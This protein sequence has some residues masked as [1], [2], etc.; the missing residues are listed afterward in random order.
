MNEVLFIASGGHRPVGREIH[1]NSYW[2]FV[3]VFYIF[4]V[5]CVFCEVLCRLFCFSVCFTSFL[6]TFLVLRCSPTY[7]VYN[8]LLYFPWFV[9]LVAAFRLLCIVLTWWRG[10]SFYALLSAKGETTLWINKKC[11]T[12]IHGLERHQY[13]EG[14]RKP[15]KKAGPDDLSHMNDALGYLI[16][17]N[18]PVQNE[19][20]TRGNLPRYGAT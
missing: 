18:M 7:S 13:D 20:I 10:Y 12:L 1:Q 6:P 5:L 19:N 14:T 17:Y 3:S 2:C 11:K 16:E 8:I 4:C 9:F 15:E